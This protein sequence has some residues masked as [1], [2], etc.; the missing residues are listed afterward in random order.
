MS[1][2]APVVLLHGFAQTPQSWD[3]VAASLQVAGHRT[4][5]P[6]LYRWLE[7]DGGGAFADNARPTGEGEAAPW[8]MGAACERLGRLVRQVAEVEGAPV[9]VGYSMGGRLV[10]E[11]LVRCSP[12]PLAGVV[13]ESAG[14]GPVDEEA[15]VALARR[16][17]AWA[18]RL[19]IEGVDAFMDWWETLPLFASQSELPAPVRRA[20]RAQRV[21]HGAEVLARSLD[22]WGAHHQTGEEATLAALAAVQAT[23]V[24]MAYLVG[25]L[26]DKYRVVAQRARGAEVPVRMVENA[27]HNVH[28]EQERA[29]L[30]VLDRLL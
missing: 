26:D 17:A 9:L 22:V 27:G 21:A 24:R 1:S 14:L 4:F 7:E 25:A 13:L 3:G 15:R 12:L 23:G 2:R 6:D 10:A 11:T 5:V 20:M 29:F 19:R 18:A 16:N 30:D 8:S 28:L